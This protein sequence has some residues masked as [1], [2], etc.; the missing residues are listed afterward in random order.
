MSFWPTTTEEPKASVSNFWGSEPDKSSGAID[1]GGGAS[2]T[3]GHAAPGM[4]AMPPV[5]TAPAQEIKLIP[6]K[7]APVKG[8]EFKVGEGMTPEQTKSAYKVFTKYGDQA[9]QEESDKA[10]SFWGLVKNTIVGTVTPEPVKIRL[11][12][13]TEAKDFNAPPI[14]TEPAKFGYSI[15][16]AIPKA[17]AIA[18][19]EFANKFQP[20]EVK[21]NIDLRRFGF[22]GPNYTTASKEFTDEVN[23]GGDP[24]QVGLRVVSDRT[25]G[26]AFGA[27]LLSDGLNLAT[28]VL[29]SG[30]VEAKI[31]AQNIL[32]AYKQ[33]QS[34]AL[35]RL[36]NSPDAEWGAQL[37][38][39]E[40][41]MADLANTKNLAQKV[42]DE[43]GAPTALDRARVN[44]S[45]YTELL[46][47]ETP[48]TKNFWGDISKPDLSLKT[49]TPKN[50][51]L[52]PKL[53]PGSREVPGQAPAMGLS[54]KEV[55][56]VGGGSKPLE[57]INPTQ[58]TRL[59][60]EDAAP[61]AAK[62]AETY[63][64]EVL[65]PAQEKGQ[66]QIIGSDDIK[67]YFGKDYNVN[68]HPVYSEAAQQLYNKAVETSPSETVKLTVGGTGSGKSDF[69]VPNLARDYNGV[70]YDSTGFN[71]EGIK[72]QIDY[73]IS[74][75]KT[76]EIYAIVPDLARSRAY[77][78]LRGAGGEHPVTEA[79]FVRTHSQAIETLKKLIEDGIDV[80]VLD[81]R[82]IHT[83]QDL[84]NAAYVEDPLALLNSLKYNE[85]NVKEAIKIISKEN[86]K[87]FI[88]KGQGAI[89]EVS[90]KNRPAKGLSKSELVEK[91][92]E[93]AKS[94]KP[95]ES[96]GPRTNK[97]KVQISDEGIKLARKA[98][99]LFQGQKKFLH[100]DLKGIVN[101]KKAFS[102]TESPL[103]KVIR[104]DYQANRKQLDKLLTEGEKKLSP[105]DAERPQSIGE[106]L[107]GR[108]ISE[109]ENFNN[110][111][112]QKLIQIDTN[113]PVKYKIGLLDYF[114]TPDRVLQ[115][116]G[117][118]NLVK[119]LRHA[120]ES[121]LAELPA[122]IDLIKSWEKRTTE[123]GAN[124][125]IF[126]YLD[127]QTNKD[128]F[129]GKNIERLS[130]KEME[131]AQEIQTYLKEWASRL[132]LPEDKQIS[133]YI[134]HIFG[135]GVNEKE[136]D[137]DIAKIID[138][139]VAGSVYDPFLQER[140][141]K[142]GYIEDTWRALDAYVKRATRKANMD[143]VLERIKEAS[144]RLELSQENFMKR[145]VD[146]IN[147]R[148]TEM[149]NLVDNTI[150][151]A[152]GYK[153]GQ[154]PVASI[155][156]A[157]RKMVYRSAL[158]LNIGSAVKNLTQGVNSYAKL[159]EKYTA[160]GYFKLM[161]LGTGELNDVGVLSQDMIQDRTISATKKNM[162]K[163]DKALFSLFDLT[164]KINRGSAYYG[165]KQRAIDQGKSEMEAIEIAKKLVRDTQFNFGS[166]DVPV[167]MN[168]SITK[169]L[170][171]FL[172]FGTK[173]TEFFAEMAKKK[174]WAGIIRYIVASTLIVGTIGKALNIK[175]Q[176]FIPG[177]SIFSRLGQTPP[178]LSLP[179][180]IIKAGVNAP[181]QYGKSRTL[182]QKGK[183][184]V[185]Q[186]PYPAK[187]QIEKSIKGA[188]A[189]SL[190]TGLMS[191]V[192]STVFGSMK[193]SDSDKILSNISKASAS[194]RTKLS[195]LDSSIVNPAQV[196]WDEVKKAGVGTD[197]ADKVVGDLSDEEYKAYAL[198]KSADDN[199]WMDIAKKVVP[200]V[201]QA[202][203]IGF[204][205]TKA[206]D[207]VNA[208]SDDEYKIYG[209]VKNSL[210]GS[211]DAGQRTWDQQGF[212]QHVTNIAKGWS[213]SPLQA[214]DDLVHGDWKIVE[215]KN[216]QIIVDRM[217]LTASEADKKAVGK[218][219]K[220]YKL[221]HIIPLASGGTNRAS[222][223]QI[224]KT[225][226]WAGNTNTEDYL[227]NALKNRTITGSQ[228]REYIIRYKGGKGQEM[229][230]ELQKEYKDKYKSQPLSEEQIRSLVKE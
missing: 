78:F 161:T 190:E 113:T 75:G 60:P 85:A 29:L 28:K 88:G 118:G 48:I 76:P 19:G 111:P 87:A 167:G 27:S 189:A 109:S 210:Y 166:I 114:R 207:L 12:F 40:K 146:K 3:S 92:V 205:K 176:D 182:T 148:P 165:A 1:L 156:S 93:K 145:Y 181:D 132:G 9:V 5:M 96:F 100:S 50:P 35:E 25:L 159:G 142:K 215:Q 169:V 217:P 123:K 219:N 30:G 59:T 31:E 178:A 98:G 34:T 230:P 36:K 108:P 163:V 229:S 140:L 206:D 124:Q 68:N 157:L 20:G 183:D 8:M 33:N 112:F 158:G 133:H 4:S 223:L 185:S 153:L 63:F 2:P 95:G 42:I 46:G 119:P 196:A 152:V 56:N 71:Y 198:I 177:A 220:D 202:D 195:A 160:I 74:K 134:T 84:Q 227:S 131:V 225:E 154:R 13:Q 208:L 125:R 91:A 105:L 77:T 186:I 86:A 22:E 121:Y 44:A 149:E 94:L 83:K 41:T 37:A 45:R 57:G 150:K 11:P 15:L 82:N 129:S 51:V 191:K 144:K 117:L 194:A 214:F 43:K 130:P 39:K 174:E 81:T 141:G 120:Y 172:S 228:A 38:K 80:N 147:M 187:V 155:S 216:G 24:L 23:K 184:I 32:N 110:T 54:T 180:A 126:R 18:G 7:P 137:E 47:R 179:W 139:K 89:R 204:G 52:E 69:L 127:G 222:N 21:A 49:S 10:N 128:Y 90:P 17:I 192:R 168:D 107:E 151:Q 193:G 67:D 55:E 197:A 199:Y 73:A 212:V 53:L 61:I 62:A 188:K 65:A 138:K 211:D 136:F 209:Q 224:I 97:P 6:P 122:H 226:D 171:Q 104:E 102:K 72:K 218:A 16:E 203:K 221:D 103:Q 143:P 115:K 201:Q 66:A 116:I 101:A 173:Q 106:I 162:E 99:K 14:I 213:T 200:V 175:A 79:A 64:K 70:V 164:E 26:L 170:T 58:E 135:I